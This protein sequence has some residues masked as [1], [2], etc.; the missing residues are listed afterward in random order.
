L[1]SPL[2]SSLPLYLD[3]F[4]RPNGRAGELPE[5]LIMGYHTYVPA[6]EKSGACYV[7][8]S[9]QIYNDLSDFQYLAQTIL[10]LLGA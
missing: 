4:L 6:F 5:E 7:R 1:L 8:V 10:E 2:P 9:A 3:S